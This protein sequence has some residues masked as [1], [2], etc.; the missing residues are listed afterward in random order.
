MSSTILNATTIVTAAPPNSQSI[1]PSRTYR[2]SFARHTPSDLDNRAADSIHPQTWPSDFTYVPAFRATN[3]HLDQAERP[4]GG[5]ALE[6]VFIT[7]ML[8]GV[9][10]QSDFTKFWEATGA[11]WWPGLTRWPIGGEW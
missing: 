7:V 9:K 10:I 2:T 4:Y 3:R 11:R 6:Y 5:N 8:Q 1:I